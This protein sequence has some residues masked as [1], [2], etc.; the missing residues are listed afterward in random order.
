MG[1]SYT[2]AQKKAT[3]KYLQNNPKK[4]MFFTARSRAKKHGMEFT[5]READILIPDTCPYLGVPLTH[6]Y[7]EGRVQSNASLD[8]IDSALGYVPGNVQVISDLA[9]RMKQDATPAQLLA[10]AQNV[11]HIHQ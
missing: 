2:E 9:N 5:I 7:G 3:Q 8:R 10:F 1:A 11:L 6:A 4:R